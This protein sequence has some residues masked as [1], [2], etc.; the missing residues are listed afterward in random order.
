MESRSWQC[1]DRFALVSPYIFVVCYMGYVAAGVLRFSLVEEQFV[2]Y[3]ET[4]LFIG[5]G[6]AWYIVG[7]QVMLPDKK[8]FYLLVIV[9]CLTFYGFQEYHVAGLVIPV[10]GLIALYIIER[11]RVKWFLVLGVSFL[12]IQLAAGGIPLID[13]ALRKASVTPLFI[14]GY[15][16]LFLG[17]A[18]MTKSW[19]MRW[20][21][22][23]CVGC[24]GLL[25]LFTF[26]VYV[27]ELVVA[28]FVSLYMLRKVTVKHV[29]ASA[30]PLV[31]LL[32]VLGYMGV[33]YQE[34]KLSPVELFFFR[35]A[36]TFG[37]LNRIVHE[38]GYLGITHGGIWLKFS[39][40]VVIGPY[41]FGYESNITS[42]I[43][44]PLIFDGGIIELGLMAFFGAVANTMYRKA[45]RDDSK[46]PYYA[47]L[48]A[49]FLVGVDVS[50]IPSIVLL[51]FVGLYL[52][53]DSGTWNLQALKKW[54]IR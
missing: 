8:E 26:R 22:A 47:I 11:G 17:M 12:V 36:F 33:R 34:W 30:I 40:A 23:A 27:V 54:S 10:V 37:V 29:V 2:I 35:P 53:S 7:C 44:G 21:F 51:F 9:A 50:F 28:V 46:V 16:F 5:I 42:T 49:M 15:S 48:L 31:L 6:L 32:V 39:S 3:P 25:S 19:D 52:A 13:S 38:A 14:L 1:M 18:F 24:I 41:L 4:F 43:L 20:V 45:L